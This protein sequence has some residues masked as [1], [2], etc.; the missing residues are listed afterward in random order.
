MTSSTFARSVR[1]ESRWGTLWTWAG[2]N[3]VYRLGCHGGAT[4][5]TVKSP[6]SSLRLILAHLFRS[7]TMAARRSIASHD[8]C[9][10]HVCGPQIETSKVSTF[11]STK[12]SYNDDVRRQQDQMCRSRNSVQSKVGTCSQRL[13]S[14]T[15][16]TL[17]CFYF[18]FMRIS[19]DE[20]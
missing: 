16:Y 20:V 5:Q 19:D 17:T 8:I 6:V 4:G 1:H 12:T 10:P 15:S 9:R 18:I 7:E 11:L 14:W 13:T 3:C 2:R